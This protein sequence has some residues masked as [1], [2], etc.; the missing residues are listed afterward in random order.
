MSDHRDTPQPISPDD[1][2]VL[3][4]IRRMTDTEAELRALLGEH[5]DLVLDPATGTPIF[6]RETQQALLQTQEQ[7]HRVNEQLEQRVQERTAELRESEERF[8]TMV[9]ALPQLAWI[10][11]ADGYIYWYNERWYAYTGATPAE[12]EGWGWQRVHDPAVLPGVL[13]TWRSS[14]ATGQPFDMEFPLRGADG[15]YR[16][17]LTRVLPLKDAEGHV[18]QWIGT[19][20]DITERK[21]AEEEREHLLSQL[22]TTINAIA[23]G[24]IIYDATRQILRMSPVAE[25]ML[26][27]SPDRQL[28]SGNPYSTEMHLVRA[29]GTPLSLEDHPSSR[30]L[31]GETVRGEVLA[32]EHDGQTSWLSISAA[33]IYGTEGDLLGAVVNFADI[34]PLHHLQEQM[35]IM[36]QIVSHDLRSPLTVIHGHVAL[37]RD[38]Q[39]RYDIEDAPATA[40]KRSGGANSG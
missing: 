12:M 23:D 4:L 35:R 24:L 6:F 34:T 5:V 37:L 29:D 8:R 13:E 1:P 31:R 18:V 21:Q 30:A 10:A 26:G 11:R 38:L 2:R 3:A 39:N 14:I 33:P 19:N 28:P 25:A 15:C 20:T 9:D 32:L 7:L 40:W 22:D 36:L 17:F 27:C 16:Q